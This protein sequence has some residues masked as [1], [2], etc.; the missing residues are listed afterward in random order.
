MFK[1][2]E[3]EVKYINQADEQ[4]NKIVSK[5]ITEGYSDEG[6]DVRTVWAD[7]TKAHTLSS[8]GYS[9]RF[10]NSQVPILTTK[11]VAWRTAIKELL[12]IWRDKSNI[13]QD[14]RDV[15]VN[16]WNEWELPSG[17]IGKALMAS[18]FT[19]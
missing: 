1:D 9:M 18:A 17:T 5:V 11:R 10:D 8:I 7:G 14:L 6:T 16:I 15:G 4:Y 12:W 2:N 3:E 13:V 19:Q